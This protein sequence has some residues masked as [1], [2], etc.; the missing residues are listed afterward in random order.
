MLRFLLHPKVLFTG[1]PKIKIKK[2]KPYI[3]A[4]SGSLGNN[5]NL[6]GYLITN[7]GKV[8][9]FSYMNNHFMNSSSKI[10][11]KMQVTLKKIRDKF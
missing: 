6:S 10:K 9:A 3:Y 1:L 2:D 4:K 7:S 8:L 11:E 5:Y